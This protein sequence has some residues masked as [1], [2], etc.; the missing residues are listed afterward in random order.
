MMNRSTLLSYH[1]ASQGQRRYNSIVMN[2]NKII[3]IYRYFSIGN[4]IASNYTNVKTKFVLAQRLSS[5]NK[6]N[7][8]KTY[9]RYV[10][11]SVI[12]HESNM[13]RSEEDGIIASPI[14]FDTNSKI[15]GEESQIVIVDIAPNEV[16]RGESGNMIYMTDGIEMSTSLGNTGSAFAKFMTGQNL[17]YSDFTYNGE[18]KGQVALGADFPSKI[19]RLADIERQPLV[20]QKGALLCYNHTVK[21]S[22]EM[23]K[24]FTTGFFGGEGFVLMK[25]TGTGDVF[26]KGGGMIIKQTLKEDDEIR[27][28]SGSLI[29]FT[30]GMDYDVSMMKGIKNIMFGGEGLFVTTLKG[31]GVVW[32]QSMSQD[33]FVSSVVSRIPSGIGF[34]LPIG[35]GGGGVSETDSDASDIAS[36]EENIQS[37]RNATVASSGF[38]DESIDSFNENTVDTNFDDTFN[39]LKDDNTSFSTQNEQ[40]NDFFDE[41]EQDKTTFSVEEEHQASMNEDVTEDKGLFSTLWDFFSD[42]E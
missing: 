21:I 12:K 3:H 41:L 23:V 42:D 31:P 37:D 2:D 25:L 19:I 27:I 17:F 22:M 26:L 10:T 35:G 24:N 32:I 30:H 14:N 1:L 15:E 33:R 20:A 34:G 11:S 38:T 28:S 18:G 7:R 5:L 39:E 40:R 36:V 8:I 16:L 9:T 6:P 13:I 4:N 29:A